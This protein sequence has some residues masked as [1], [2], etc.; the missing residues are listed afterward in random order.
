[1]SSPCES[2]MK[3]ENWIFAIF[4]LT[5][6][7][8]VVA[9]SSAF[10]QQNSVDR[11]RPGSLETEWSGLSSPA[12]PVSDGPGMGA[13]TTKA[14]L[15][16][17]RS[18]VGVAEAGGKVYVVGG[19]AN[20]RVDQPLNQEYDP[21]SNTWRQRAPMLRGANHIATIG[22]DGKLYAIGGFLEQNFSAIADLSAYNP[23]SDRWTALAPLPTPLGSMAVAVLE[24]RIHAVGGAGGASH[25]ERKTVNVHFVYDVAANTWTESTPLPFPREHLNLI[26]LNGT[27]YAIGGRI[28]TYLQNVATVYAL[29]PAKDIEWKELPLMP[30]A[31]SGT[32]AAVLKGKIFVFG[33][34]R[35][36]GVFNQSE[37]FDPDTLRWSK[38]TPM[39]VGRHGTNAATVGDS[40]YI[41]AGGPLNGGAAQTN[42]NQ[43]FTYP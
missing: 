28:D 39:P 6:T 4:A 12:E 5:I 29:N 25:S 43:A 1:M 3:T 33:G 20:G 17:A 36:G 24:G 34:E 42:A 21:A 18:E 2:E 30:T 14:G 41:P 32:Q 8:A 9:H 37:M 13:W 22:F 11:Q 27:L 16:T 19:Y 10:G 40:I 38:L 23:S 15:P 26:A 31:R 35:L 7:G